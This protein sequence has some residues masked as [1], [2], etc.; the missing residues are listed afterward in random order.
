MGMSH[1]MMD[2]KSFPMEQ[3]E[4]LKRTLKEVGL[5]DDYQYFLFKHYDHKADELI[6]GMEHEGALNSILS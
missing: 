2:Y 6:N 1:P 3:K 5:P 4:K